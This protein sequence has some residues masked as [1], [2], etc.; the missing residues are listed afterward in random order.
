MFVNLIGL[1][2]VFVVV[3][4]K[5]VYDKWDCI[6]SYFFGKIDEVKVVFDEGLLNGVFKFFFEFNLF[7]LVVEGM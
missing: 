4:V 2:I 3:L 1:I 6:V 5:V 7:V